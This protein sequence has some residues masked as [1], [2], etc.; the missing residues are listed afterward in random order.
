MTSAEV[1][2]KHAPFVD[3]QPLLESSDLKYLSKCRK[4]FSRWN[5]KCTT[6]HCSTKLKGKCLLPDTY[7]LMVSGIS[8]VYMSSEKYVALKPYQEQIYKT[9]LV[10]AYDFYV[11]ITK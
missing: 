3:N 5:L 6:L 4:V 10:Y 9:T 8:L 2:Y 11:T 7:I 1:N